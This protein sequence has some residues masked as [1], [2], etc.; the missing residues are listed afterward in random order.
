MRVIATSNLAEYHRN[1]TALT[2]FLGN[3]TKA[4]I[5]KEGRLLF[6]T[7]GDET[8]PQTFAKGRKNVATQLRKAVSL[9]SLADFPEEI[10]SPLIR[11]LIR[12]RNYGG[13]QAVI[14]RQKSGPL[15]G[16]TLKPF[17]RSLHE[18][19]RNSRGGV[20]KNQKVATL[21]KA[22]W[23]EHLKRKQSH[24]GMAKGGWVAGTRALGGRSRN[25]A[26]RWASMGSFRNELD[27]L[28]DANVQAT[29]NA[30]W[31]DGGAETDTFRRAVRSRSA[32]LKV[33]LEAAVRGAAYKTLK[34]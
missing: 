2:E 33:A 20:S 12:E 17:T 25:F 27:S 5:R 13:L 7:L 14:D 18:D 4:A 32:S 34:A 30:P 22:E 23:R 6:Q 24:V 15:K 8:P 9:L 16:V 19:V 3:D 28:T 26:N 10:R 11:K 1:F 21:D 31:A 29:N